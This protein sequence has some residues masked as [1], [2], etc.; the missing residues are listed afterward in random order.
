MKWVLSLVCCC[1]MAAA[2]VAEPVRTYTQ[3]DYPGSSTIPTLGT[4]PGEI[5]FS[6]L[7]FSLT[8]FDDTNDLEYS[9]SFMTLD[10]PQEYAGTLTFLGQTPHNPFSPSNR[11]YA[12]YGDGSGADGG[13]LTMS[14]FAQGS[15]PGINAADLFGDFAA[16]LLTFGNDLVQPIYGTIAVPEPS[17]KMFAWLGGAGLLVFQHARRRRAVGLETRN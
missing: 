7:D 3:A 6:P 1:L 15:T 9:F 16:T 2:V 8:T 17:I 10:G 5:L 4:Q 12:D 13:H 14:M 11:N